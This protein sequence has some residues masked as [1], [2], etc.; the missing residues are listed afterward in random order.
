MLNRT[1]LLF[2][3]FDPKGFG[4]EVG[5]SYNPLLP[6]CRG[7]NVE[8]VDHA[9]ATALREKYRDNASQIEEVDYVSDGR[10]L[11]ETIGQEQRYDFI[12]A[13]HVIEHVTDIVRFI[14]DC[15]VLLKPAGRLVLAVPDK[16]FC[17][18]ALRPLSTVGQALQAYAEQRKRH[19]PGILFD[20]VSYFCTKAQQV[21]WLEPTFD[22]VSLLQSG[23][24]AKNMAEAVQVDRAYYD[25]H[26]WQF[27]PASFRFL[28][29]KLRSLGYIK[30]GE[31]AFHKNEPSQLHLHEFYISLTKTA[32]VLEVSD[33]DLFKQA[34]A[35]LREIAVDRG[36]LH[37]NSKAA[38]LRHQIDAVNQQI[39]AANWQIQLL[40]A[41]NEALL[42]STSWKLTAPLRYVR[43]A[44]RRS[45]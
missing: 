18:D 27:T 11:L 45:A 7:F 30:S 9:N 44:L 26:A 32:P 35:E 33:V 15:E 29:K 14:Q 19:T 4:L 25:A 22:D 16:R 34:E 36:G 13:S 20:Q 2:S 5:P 23:E 3:M 42:H 24:E 38:A 21:V 31:I 6:K 39:E 40:A 8:I 43:S 1:E 37:L 10:S 41:R 28:V 17:F 12:F